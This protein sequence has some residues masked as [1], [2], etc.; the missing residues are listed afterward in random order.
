MD[1]Y[2]PPG[3]GLAAPEMLNSLSGLEFMQRLAAGTIPPPP[4]AI[5]LGFGIA[6]VERGKVTVTSRVG[7]HAY[8]PMGTIHGGYAATLLDTC[9]GCAVMTG[10]ERGYAYTT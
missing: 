10:V 6:S 1:V 3:S 4:I 9:M 2:Y 8:N 7:A 5:T